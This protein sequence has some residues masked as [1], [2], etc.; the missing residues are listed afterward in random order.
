[1]A[2]VDPAT[3]RVIRRTEKIVVL[4]SARRIG[5]SSLSDRPF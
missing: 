1:M 2:Q 4:A 3:L 5:E